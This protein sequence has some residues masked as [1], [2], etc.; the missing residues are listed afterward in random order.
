MESDR[1]A[2]NDERA[3]IIYMLTMHSRGAAEGRAGPGGDRREKCR[4]DLQTAKPVDILFVG[5][6]DAGLVASDATEH[7]QGPSVVLSHLLPDL[8]LSS[9]S[10]GFSSP[11]RFLPSPSFRWRLPSFN[12]KASYYRGGGVS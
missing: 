6:P 9:G 3:D 5:R 4:T 8:L 1:G 7:L 11:S 2:G 12:R 10:T